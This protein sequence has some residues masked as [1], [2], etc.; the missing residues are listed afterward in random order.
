MELISRK[1]AKEKNLKL[2]FTGKP[3]K[4]GHLSQRETSNGKCQDCTVEY[5]LKYRA[6]N[7][8]KISDLGKSW[9]E[10]NKDKT[11]KDKKEWYSLNREHCCEYAS[12]YYKENRESCND[13]ASARRRIRYKE[14][15]NFKL[16]LNLGKRLC[17][18][19]K[20]NEQRGSAID[21]L[22]CSIEFLKTYLESKFTQDMSWENWGYRGWHI[23]HIKPLCSFDLANKDQLKLSCHYTNLQPLWALDNQRK[24]GKI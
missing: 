3:C 23:D 11:K 12:H 10:S 13:T 17:I 1:D 2:Y 7:K 21:N 20:G 8:E 5:N 16:K 14:D 6:E 22:G 24:S 19:I 15:T 4:W 9:R 18:A